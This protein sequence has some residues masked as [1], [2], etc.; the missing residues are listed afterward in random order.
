MTQPRAIISLQK[1]L[2]APNELEPS[3]EVILDGDQ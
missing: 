3:G 1:I 2:L